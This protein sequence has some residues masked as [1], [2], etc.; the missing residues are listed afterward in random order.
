MIAR[1]GVVP[2]VRGN[3]RLEL[4]R[5]RR[6]IMQ[7]KQ[8]CLWMLCLGM[9]C[10]FGYAQDSEPPKTPSSQLKLDSSLKLEPAPR[11]IWSTGV[12]E[13]FRKGAKNVGFTLGG[14][15]SVEWFGSSEKHGLALASVYYGWVFS[16][17]VG[18]GHWYNGNWELRAEVFGGVQYDEHRAYVVG[19]LPVIRYNFAT[20]TR[21]VP[22]IDFGAG[23]TA[24]DIGLQDL[25][26]TFEFN[27]QGGVGVRYFWR[28]DVA[29]T[30][31]GRFMHL[32]NAS[33]DKPNNGVNTAI[34]SFG[35]SWFF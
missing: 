7:K 9:G 29:F 26:T 22:F 8:L 2:V 33:I 6:V 5:E 35:V 15:P 24:T 25:S 28:D 13:G 34:F 11:Q 20:G 10:G 21:W 16:D 1:L 18:A 23:V 14:G 27:E 31:Q 4:R 30:F 32:S 3:H 19:A 12:G 17:V